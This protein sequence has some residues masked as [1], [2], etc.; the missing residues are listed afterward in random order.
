MGYSCEA[1]IDL[2][3]DDI[4]SQK[5]SVEQIETF[6]NVIITLKNRKTSRLKNIENQFFNELNYYLSFTNSKQKYQTSTTISVTN[7]LAVLI[8]VIAIF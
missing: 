3:V 1:A 6:K 4:E 5:F 8:I 7:L 2:K